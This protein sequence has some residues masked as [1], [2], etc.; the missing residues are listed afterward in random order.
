M[1]SRE[2]FVPVSDAFHSSITIDD[3]DAFHVDSSHA[4]LG[5]LDFQFFPLGERNSGIRHLVGCGPVTR[6]AVEI[7]KTHAARGTRRNGKGADCTAL[8]HL[9]RKEKGD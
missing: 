5:V 2:E 7:R 8:S 1:S 4:V 6:L 9:E 3:P